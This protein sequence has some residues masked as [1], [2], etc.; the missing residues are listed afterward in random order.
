MELL[1]P[2]DTLL[3]LLVHWLQFSHSGQI[4]D[5]CLVL[6]NSLVGKTSPEVRLDQNIDIVD[7]QRSIKHLGTVIDLLLILLVFTIAEGNIAKDGS[8]LLRD[9]FFEH[10]KV[11]IG[12]L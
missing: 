2:L 3:C 11:L 10:P 8:L 7:V 6:L 1:A 5:S 9:F 12:N 4:I